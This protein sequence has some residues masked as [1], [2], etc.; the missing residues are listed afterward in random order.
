MRMP[1]WWWISLFGVII[2]LISSMFMWIFLGR[3][4]LWWINSVIGWFIG[5]TLFLRGVLKK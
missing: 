2:L 3:N 1:K 4:R 5:L